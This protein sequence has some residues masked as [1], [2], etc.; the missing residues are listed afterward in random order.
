MTSPLDRQERFSPPSDSLRERL[1]AHPLEHPDQARDLVRRLALEQGWS[2]SQARAAIEE[3]RRFCYLACVAGHA[4]TPSEEVDMVW[5]LH[6]L[7]TRDYWEVFCPQVLQRPLHHGPTLG[8]E[9]E[10]HRFYQQYAETLASYQTHFGPP[11]EAWWPR[12]LDRFQP[13]CRWRWVYLP[14]AWV[15]P[16]PTVWVRFLVRPFRAAFS[17]FSIANKR[18]A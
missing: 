12:A 15:I 2:I 8:G 14:T 7:H 1:W 10:E 18:S 16:K 5:H 17:W 6:L 13:S 9:Q 11:P 4:V 3:Y